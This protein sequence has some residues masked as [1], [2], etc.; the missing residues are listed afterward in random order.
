M[1]TTML[2]RWPIALLPQAF[3]P[4][5]RT[6]SRASSQTEGRRPLARV[7]PREHFFL[8]CSTTIFRL[9]RVEIERIIWLDLGLVA[10]RRKCGLSCLAWRRRKMVRRRDQGLNKGTTCRTTNVD[11]DV[12][13]WHRP[14]R[15]VHH[16]WHHPAIHPP[17]HL[18]T[19]EPHG[20]PPTHHTLPPP[21]SPPPR[22]RSS[23]PRSAR[24]ASTMC[25]RATACA[26]CA[27][28]ASR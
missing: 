17:T 6:Q 9:S 16:P 25:T 1:A 7:L 15:I 24:S 13:A 11:G 4:V 10:G 5:P 27:A 23:K 14:Q 26:W 19:I 20:S 22:S 12:K 21:P 3:R 2:L 8:L 18:P 28:T